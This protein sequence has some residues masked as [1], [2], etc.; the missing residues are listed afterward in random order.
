[1]GKLLVLSY[2]LSRTVFILRGAE[3]QARAEEFNY[4]AATHR[5]DS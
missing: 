3:A 1:M 5:V 4:G 2:R